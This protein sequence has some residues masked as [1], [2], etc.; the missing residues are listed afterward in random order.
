MGL[1]NFTQF[2]GTRWFGFNKTAKI[3]QSN[4]TFPYDEGFVTSSDVYSV[5]S[6]ISKSGKH[7]PWILTDEVRG[8]EEVVESGDLFDLIQQPNKKQSRAQFVELALIYLLLSGED[9]QKILKPV[10]MN[11]VTEV[12]LLNPQLVDVLVTRMGTSYEATGYTFDGL[13]GTISTEDVTHLTYANPTVE[14]TESL[15]GLSPLVAG[16]LTLKGLNHNQEANATI[17]KNQGAAGI[18]SNESENPLTDSEREQAQSVLDK[19]IAGVRNFGKIIQS[20]AK[21][22]FTR[23][24]LDPSQLKLIESKL[25]KFRD[26]CAIYDV[27]SIL[28][29]D[30]VNASHNN[31]INAEKALWTNAVIPNTQLIVDMF[32][33]GV[34]SEFNK[35]SGH[36]FKVK[37]DISQIAILQTD[38]KKEAEKDK[39]KMVGINILLNMN[40][41]VKGKIELLV[42]E[43]GYTE[44]NAKIIAT[45]GTSG[46]NGEE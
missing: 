41:S 5:S 7:L 29:N 1:T 9:F 31:L 26:L 16:Y 12:E 25:L 42:S 33:D 32:N 38:L 10:G 15:R 43:Y 14:G 17:L 45:P 27:R 11:I 44:E 22:K 8:K 24:G 46:N 23:L 19:L 36:K 20:S 2:N 35:D 40:N 4:R 6:K 3:S 21:V 37:L 13:P 30:P 34:V 18:L 28:F 39:I